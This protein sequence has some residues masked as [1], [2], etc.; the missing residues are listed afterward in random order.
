M[1][2]RYSWK[3]ILTFSC[4][5]GFTAASACSSWYS[6]WAHSLTSP[7][8]PKTISCWRRLTRQSAAHSRA[9]KAS[10][11]G[12]PRSGVASLTRCLRVGMKPGLGDAGLCKFAHGFTWGRWRHSSRRLR[13]WRILLRQ[14]A[15]GVRLHACMPRRSHGPLCKSGRLLTPS[16]IP[17]LQLIAQ[18]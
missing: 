13:R 7:A 11:C 10:S 17:L 1:G 2:G 14:L 12:L 9:Q 5:A 16:P 3:P 18:G 4:L 8:H 6:A 15:V